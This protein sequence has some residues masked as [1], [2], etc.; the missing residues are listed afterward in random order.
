LW[1]PATTIEVNRDAQTNGKSNRESHAATQNPLKPKS[2]C[3]A[4][5]DVHRQLLA[6][7]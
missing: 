1:L 6:I 2:P 3:I 7:G 4:W 5:L